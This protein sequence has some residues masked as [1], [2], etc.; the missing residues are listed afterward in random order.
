MAYQVKGVVDRSFTKDKTSKAGR[1]VTINYIE[2]DGV[3]IST[4]FNREHQQGE[5]INIGV[6]KKFNEIQKVTANGDGMP[7][8]SQLTSA[9][10][11]VAKGNFGGGGGGWKGGAKSKFPIDPTDGQM[12]IIRQSSMNRAVEIIDQMTTAG[13][14]KPDNEQEYL[15]KLLEIALIVADFGSGQDIMQM[16]AIAAERS[17]VNE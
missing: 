9:P 11:P 2:V 1:N 7:P 4:G 13:L 17:I 10:A 14:F 3:T 5:M 12:S 6:D 15:R 8:V 16:Q